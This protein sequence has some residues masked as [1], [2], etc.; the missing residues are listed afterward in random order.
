MNLRIASLLLLLVAGLAA[1]DRPKPKQV[2]AP[3][4]PAT[5]QETLFSDITPTADGGA[6]AV[7]LESGL[8][9]LRGTQ[10]VKVRFPDTPTNNEDLSFIGIEITPLMDGGAYARSITGKTLWHLREA[11]AEPVSE[12]PSLITTP[13]SGPVNAFPLYVAERQKRL[14]AEQ[15]LEERPSV[16]DAREPPDEDP[17]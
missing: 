2:Q 12:A 9:F 10:A 8:W 6:Y 14:Q 3:R 11:T 1:C 15:Q 16:D 13:L 5:F 7:G 4:K 17:Y